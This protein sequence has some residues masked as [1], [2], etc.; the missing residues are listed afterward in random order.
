MRAAPLVP[1][2]FCSLFSLPIILHSGAS[3]ARKTMEM[4]AAFSFLDDEGSE[5][6]GEPKP[7]SF[8]S[9]QWTFSETSFQPGSL[10]KS[11]RD[12]LLIFLDDDIIPVYPLTN[13]QSPSG[14]QSIALPDI[15]VDFVNNVVYFLKF[16]FSDSGLLGAWN[17]AFGR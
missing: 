16:R 5:S 1:A 7:A 4:A 8:S 6:R 2:G 11:V 12:H 10:L 9:V 3:L 14:G 17:G 15:E 13:S